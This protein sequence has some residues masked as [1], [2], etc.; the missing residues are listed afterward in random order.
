[1]I[2]LYHFVQL[3]GSILVVEAFGQQSSPSAHGLSEAVVLE[4]PDNMPDELAVRVCH[5]HCF[6]TYRVDAECCKA[7]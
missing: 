7:S 5:E 4:K 3:S 1:M 2:S 6:A